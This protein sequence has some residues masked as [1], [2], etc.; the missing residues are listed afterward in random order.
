MH[1]SLQTH[2]SRSN[3]AVRVLCGGKANT[4]V[5]PQRVRF[6]TIRHAAYPLTTA[7]A[8]QGKAC[9]QT[10]LESQLE[11]KPMDAM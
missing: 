3:R 2:I 9:F 6:L 8:E 10:H 4:E 7:Q 11:T 1:A 5:S